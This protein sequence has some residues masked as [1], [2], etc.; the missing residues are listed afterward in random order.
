MTITKLLLIAAVPLFWQHR[1]AILL[2][3]VA[4]GSIGSHMSARYRYYSIIYKQVIRCGD[5]PGTAGLDDDTGN[6]P[7]GDNNQ[8]VE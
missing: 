6:H 7:A 5:G 4:L 1:L 8:R 2:A 3:V